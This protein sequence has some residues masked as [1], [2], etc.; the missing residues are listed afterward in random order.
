MVRN[1]WD[2]MRRQKQ[3][4]W[5]TAGYA[6]AAIIFPFIVAAPRY[7]HG[8]ISLGA[9]VQTAL[10]FGQV[11]DALSFI[12]SS[13]ADIAEWRSV[14]ARLAGF[15]RALGRVRS[16]AAGT[17][18]VHAD[19][20]AGRLTVEALELDL[21]H[22]QPLVAGVTLALDRG[23]TALLSGPPGAGKSTLLRAIA[24]IWPFG[25]GEIRLPRGARILVLP[26]KP[27]LPNGTLREV[28]TY[29]APEGRVDDAALQ[30]ALEAVDFPG[31]RSG[32]TRPA[33]GGFDFRPAN[34]NGSLL[35]G[36]SSTGLTGSSST[37]PRQRWTR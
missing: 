23:G 12:I 1:W 20:E 31:W 33:R 13:Y 5:F 9:L 19:G 28:A 21:P 27:Y 25:H 18:I 3:L 36:R 24:G 14:V 4:T 16:P 11:Q 17:G 10:A 15:E 6:Q 35:S 2:I 8:E 29:P 26:Q 32:S 22:G 7:F 34:S 30:E 37:K